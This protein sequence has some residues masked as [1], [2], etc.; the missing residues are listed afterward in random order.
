M[1]I[2]AGQGGNAGTQTMTIIVRSL[3]LKEIAP[4]DAGWALWHEARVGIVN[5]VTVGLLVALIAGLWQKSPYL[6][7]VLGLAMLGNLVVAGRW[8]QLPDPVAGLDMVGELL[9]TQGRVLPMA[10]VPLT[11]E[12]DVFG[13]D[14]NHP[15][16]L[17]VLRGQ[18]TV[19]KTQ[20]EVLS[21]R[22]VPD[23][24]AARPEGVARVPAAIP[25][26]RSMPPPRMAWPRT[27]AACVWRWPVRGCW[28]QA[29]PG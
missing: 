11:I 18:A 14:P 9:R 6:G 16:E 22:L 2:V 4:R 5:G 8:Q 28:R 27:R 7:L 10:A 29:W 21:V 3:A 15:D 12:A 19:A 17:S 1:P 23:R 20:G 24:P 13:A 26:R 25:A